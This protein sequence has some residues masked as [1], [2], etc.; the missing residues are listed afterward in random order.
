M[1]RLRQWRALARI[2]QVHVSGRAAT[3]PRRSRGF[4]LCQA[5]G[6]HTGGVVCD[7]S[8]GSSLHLVHEDGNNT[9]ANR[10]SGGGQQRAPGPL[11][12]VLVVDWGYLRSR[13]WPVDRRALRVH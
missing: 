7:P 1:V 9:E 5:L 8:P 12:R 10:C 3:S 13:V 2:L 6:N 4:T 11:T